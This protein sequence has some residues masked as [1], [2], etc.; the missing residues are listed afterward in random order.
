LVNSEP[1]NVNIDVTA[2]NDAPVA[3]PQSVTTRQSASVAIT[4]SG[5]DIDSAVLTYH[6]VTPP[7]HGTLSGAVPYLTYT[8]T[9]GYADL[10]A[11]SFVANDGELDSAPATVSIKINYVI[12]MSVLF[13]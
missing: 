13:R 10:D 11:F 1:A 7:E 12:F 4:L 9:P 2:V 3:D 5:L 8:P 6:V